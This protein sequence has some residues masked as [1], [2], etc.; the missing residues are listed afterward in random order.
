MLSQS[1]R[2]SAFLVPLL[3]AVQFTAAHPAYAT[4]FEFDETRTIV[5]FAYTMAF[6]T[7][8]GHF[9][10]V[11]GTLDYD[12]RR[13]EKIRINA[14]IA[15]ASLSTGAAIIDRELKGASFFN[16]DASPVIDFKSRA[17]NSADHGAA[18]IA[19]DITINGITRPVTLTVALKPSGPAIAPGRGAQGFIATGRIQRSA[20]NMTGWKVMVADEIDIE[21][22]GVLRPKS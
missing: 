5:R 8:H 10:R 13:P 21:I 7:H 22:D 20:F 14:A 3:L 1:V 4:R 11:A 15:A 2:R 17:V 16:V 9:T 6:T 12:E 18:E 19:G